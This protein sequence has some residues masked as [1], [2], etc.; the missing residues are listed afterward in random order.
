[1]IADPLE[2]L[3]LNSDTGLAIAQVAF[4]RGHEVFWTTEADTSLLEGEVFFYAQKI[5]AYVSTEKGP[6]ISEYKTLSGRELD[7]VLIRKDPPFDEKYVKLCWELGYLNPKVRL[8][9]HPNQ[10]LSY[11]EKLFP[12]LLLKEKILDR[13]EI[14]PT[15]VPARNATKD[16]PGFLENNR[17]IAKPFYG[18]GGNGVEIHDSIEEAWEAHAPEFRATKLFQPYLEDIL[19]RGDRRVLVIDGKVIGSFTRFPK[20]GSVISNLAQGGSAQSL[21]MSEEERN[22]SEK[23]AKCLAQKRISL[24]GLDLIGPRLSEINITAPTGFR[25]VEELEGVQAST[26]YVKWLEKEVNCK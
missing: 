11:H 16:F 2:S 25:H 7:V 1:M 24:A 10:L 15:W 3:Q 9:N 6:Q 26:Q 13:N 19:V 14:I 22:L 23:V 12:F 18:F 21:A 5:T 8:F 17:V 20:K 4:E